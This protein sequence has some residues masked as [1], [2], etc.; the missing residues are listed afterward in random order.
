MKMKQAL[1]DKKSVYKGQDLSDKPKTLTHALKPLIPKMGNMTYD[2]IK[3]EFIDILN[4]ESLS[5]SKESRQKYLNEL[6][7]KRT[8]DQLMPYICNV[9]LKGS[10]LGAIR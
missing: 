10:G 5:I 7:K 1:D 6:A 3:K 9:E 4:S 2:E 8:K